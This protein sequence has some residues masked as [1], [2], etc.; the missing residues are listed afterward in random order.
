MYCGVLRISYGCVHRWGEGGCNSHTP[1][2]TEDIAEDI[3]MISNPILHD[4]IKSEIDHRA[5]L[6]F[7]ICKDIPVLKKSNLFKKDY[8]S[9]SE[10]RQEQLNRRYYQA[11]VVWFFEGKEMDNYYIVHEIKTGYYEFSEIYQKYRTGMNGQIWIWGWNKINNTKM[12]PD[13]FKRKIRII[14]IEYLKPLL[15]QELHQ[16][17]MGLDE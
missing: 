13:K 16:I 9:F 17:L 15:K 10:A 4:I 2:T 11:D 12:L 8:W 7:D 1:H 14:D 3:V 6:V 5:R